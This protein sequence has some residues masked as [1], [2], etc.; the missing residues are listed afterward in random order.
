MR[1]RTFAGPSEHCCTEADKY[2]RIFLTLNL[3]YA[4]QIMVSDD[5]KINKTSNEK[6]NFGQRPIV[7]RSLKNVY[8]SYTQFECHVTNIHVK[9]F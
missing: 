6:V 3:S 5:S 2:C 7:S 4:G 8:V 9:L 1:L